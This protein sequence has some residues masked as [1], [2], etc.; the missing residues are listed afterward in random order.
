MLQILREEEINDI[1]IGSTF[2]GAGGGGSPRDGKKL[3]DDLKS[4][5]MARVTMID[6]RDMK[7]DEHAVMIAEFGSPKAFLEV[8]S[9][10]ETVK[11]FE[12][13]QEISEEKGKKIAFIMAG[14]LG[15][16]N[17]IVPMYVSALKGVPFLN[18]DAQGRAV[19]EL[20]T[21]LYNVHHFS[22]S[23]FVM[24]GY[25]GDYVVAYLNDPGDHRAAESIARHM[26][27]AYGSRA[28]FAGIEANR[29][30]IEEKLVPDSIILCMNVGK[31]FRE[32]SDLKEL[33]NTLVE[34]CG[35][36]KIFEGEI[37]KIE[38]KSEGGFDYGVT[39]IKGSGEYRGE[40]I[41]VSFKNE[42]ILCQ[43]SSGKV[44]GTVPDL[45]T[46]VDA[47]DL[48]PLTNADTSEGQRVAVFGL[49]A[50]D[51]WFKSPEGFNCWKYILLKLGYDGSYIP[52]I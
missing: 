21:C 27:M 6:F 37:E 19:P 16:F 45:I 44:I 52:V 7:D 25:T 24:A 23:P 14:E 38:V 8:K 42:N 36:M 26:A 11:A 18:S 12:V 49:R 20:S 29:R 3:I 1:M 34:T 46:L 43:N 33:V 9:F 22:F 15:G 28:G 10:P 17:T 30:D 35:A 13:L 4:K 48:R 40:S 31:A 41:S 50:P 47:E 5:G 39:T 2:F 51:A 32:A